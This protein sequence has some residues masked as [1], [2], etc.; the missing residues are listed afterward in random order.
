MCFSDAANS[1]PV[2]TSSLLEHGQFPKL[3]VILGEHAQVF[4]AFALH[5]LCL[6]ACDALSHVWLIALFTF[7]LSRP[8]LACL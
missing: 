3:L 8:Q 2:P 5:L 6:T 7:L 1:G 4:D